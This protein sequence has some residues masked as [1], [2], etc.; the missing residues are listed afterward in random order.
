LLWLTV[1]RLLHPAHPPVHSQYSRHIFNSAD[2]QPDPRP[3]NWK[4]I[5]QPIATFSATSTTHRLAPSQ[6]PYTS[7]V[8]FDTPILVHLAT[9][10]RSSH[11]QP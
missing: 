4:A 1:L 7:G 10:S 2:Q 11:P 5:L 3:T 8:R 9:R 6:L